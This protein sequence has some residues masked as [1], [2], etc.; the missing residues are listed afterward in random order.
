MTTTQDIRAEMGSIVTGAINTY[1]QAKNDADKEAIQEQSWPAVRMA[2][3]A[4]GVR[5]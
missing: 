2:P 3:G 4:F 1:Y 5:G